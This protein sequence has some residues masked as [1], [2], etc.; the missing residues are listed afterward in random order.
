M[1]K[2]ITASALHTVTQGEVDLAVENFTKA[3]NLMPNFA[4]AYYN[5]GVAY[6]LKGKVDDAIVDWTKAIEL[7]SDYADAYNNRGIV[8]ISIGEVNRA[9]IDLN[10]FI[11]LRPNNAIA[12]Y[13]RTKVWLLLRE[14]EKVKSDLIKARVL[15]LDVVDVFRRDYGSVVNFEQTI[16]IQLPAD[17]AALLTLRH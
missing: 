7:D 12:Y 13:R 9:L 2:H 4:Q 11:Q 14:W 6:N 17:I 8:Y 1:P 15:G 16:G 10:Q 5:R 3:I